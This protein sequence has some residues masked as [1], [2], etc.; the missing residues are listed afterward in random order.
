MSLSMLHAPCSISIHVG[1]HGMA[2]GLGGDA[3][4]LP[5]SVRSR[6]RRSRVRRRGPWES[7]KVGECSESGQ[8]IRVPCQ[9]SKG[10]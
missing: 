1:A 6:T 5:W 2:F 3:G 7:G 4:C 8:L 10:I 9:S